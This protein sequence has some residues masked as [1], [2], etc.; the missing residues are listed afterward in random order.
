MSRRPALDGLRAFA[1]LAVMAFHT[2]PAAHGGFLGVDVFFVISGYL[3]TAL[4]LREWS[5]SG[6]VDLKAFYVKRALR[7]LPPLLFMLAVSLP[8]VFTWARDQLTLNPVIAIASVLLYVANWANVWVNEGTGI[9]THTWSLSIEE[10]FYLIW[11]LVLIGVLARR[12]KAP[13]AGL[14]VLIA[15]VVLA[16]WVGVANSDSFLWIYYATTSHCDGLLL[17]SLLAV[18]LNRRDSLA[19]SGRQSEIV[20]W[21]GVFGLAALFATS[22]I[23]TSD[24]YE[25]RL[26]MAALFAT[27]IVHHLATR[28][29]GP[30]VDLLS[31]RP[32]VAVGMVSYGLYLYHFPVFMTV[33]SRHYPHL[34]QHALEIT[35]TLALTVFSWFVV[36][37]PAL[38]LKD[39]LAGA[40]VA[41]VTVTVALPGPATVEAG[42]AG[43][44][45]SAQALAAPIIGYAPPGGV[46]GPRV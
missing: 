39:R 20:A 2:S 16:R 24:T 34:E 36:E 46:G 8:F 5:R 11:P 29:Q 10:Q 25:W 1:V 35:L 42:P 26:P 23:E 17:G 45:A 15:L 4:L 30:M 28:K 37:K 32:F 44:A 6:G 43:M 19:R 41:P 33:Q 18:L 21:A 3:I 13:A 9:W 38:R 31:L 27:M 22:H 40:P 14:V 7:L 12:K